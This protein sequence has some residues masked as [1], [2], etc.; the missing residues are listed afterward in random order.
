MRDVRD[1]VAFITGG[2]SGIGL[3]MARAFS[4][5]G[6]KVV[7][8]DISSEA[9]AAASD[10]LAG[11][12]ARALPVLLDVTDRQAW[13]TV[14][15]RVEQEFGSVNVLCNNAGLSVGAIP[16]TE[17]SAARWDLLMNVN[18]NGV[19]N[20]VNAFVKRFIQDGRPAHIV[21]TASV[22][23][24]FCSGPNNT[25]Y[26]TSKFALVGL[27]EAL[28][29]ELRPFGIGVSVLC[30]G[31]VATE[32]ARNSRKNQPPGEAHPQPEEKIERRHL[33]LSLAM[34]PERVGERVLKAIR[35]NEFFIITHPEY[36]PV[37]EARTKVLLAACHDSAQPGYQ[38]DIKSAGG[39]WLN[40]AA[41]VEDAAK[42]S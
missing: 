12:G 8:A 9:L 21:N 2:S 30:P 22:N 11:A 3:G 20:G 41:A 13:P 27:S 24:L 38:E 33:M 42:R 7:I 36:R 6:M 17:L 31:G 34:K 16:L 28:L 1:K 14:V 29:F 40:Y 10:E 32:I 26:T 4:A 25:A 19:F 35:H 5:A 18:L 15:E 23:G 39:A 37:I